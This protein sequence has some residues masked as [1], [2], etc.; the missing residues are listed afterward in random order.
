MFFSIHF[1]AKRQVG[2][3][4]MELAFLNDDSPLPS[5][6][7]TNIVVIPKVDSP[8]T[9]KEFR[10]ISLCNVVVKVISKALTNQFQLI[11]PMLYR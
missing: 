11:L 8:S 1:L 7:H 6:N 10:P 3:V 5:L 4:L 9:E 2:L